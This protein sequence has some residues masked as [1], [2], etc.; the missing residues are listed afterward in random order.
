MEKTKDN[1]NG[2]QQENILH[3][4][5][6]PKK[7]DKLTETCKPT[8]TFQISL[9]VDEHVSHLNCSS[10]TEDELVGEH[11]PEKTETVEDLL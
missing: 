1:K 7:S 5:R 9:R 4:A 10:R 11:V 2:M 8:R 6:N 3:H